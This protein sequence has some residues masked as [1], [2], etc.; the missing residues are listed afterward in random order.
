MLL[1]GWTRGGLSELKAA[2]T[3]APVTLCQVTNGA[4]PRNFLMM[5]LDCLRDS[6][7]WAGLKSSQ[8]MTSIFLESSCGVVPVSANV[9]FLKCGNVKVTHL[10]E[11]FLFR[12]IAFILQKACMEMQLL[13]GLIFVNKHL[14]SSDLQRLAVVSEVT[15]VSLPHGLYHQLGDGGDVQT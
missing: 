1:Q 14:G 9:S 5:A 7:R 3:A 12:N 13:S 10:T 8:S 6:A 4:L 15:L 2:A 11:F